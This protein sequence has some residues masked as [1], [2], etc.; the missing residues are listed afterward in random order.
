MPLPRFQ[1]IC[2]LRPGHLIFLLRWAA[3]LAGCAIAD[4]SAAEGAG[5]APASAL[6]NVRDQGAA[7][8]GRTLDSAALQRAIDLCAERGGGTVV[9]PA[10]TYLTG[11]LL[12]KNGVRLR[13][14]EGAT[15]LGSLSIADYRN[16][17]VFRDGTGAELGYALIAAVDAKDVALE[18]KGVIDGR[19]KQVLDGLAKAEHNKRPMLVRFVRCQRVSAHGVQLRNSA[20]WTANFFQ[21]TDVAIDGL[22]IASRGVGNNDGID[23]DSC[24]QVSITGCDIDS[25]DDA[26]CLKTT[27]ARPCRAISIADCRLK[28][29]HGAIKFGTESCANFE[30]ITVARCAIRETRN[31]GIKL[32]AVDGAHIRNVTISDLTMD[33]V[34][35]P[36]FVRLGAR[37]KTFRAGD[38]KRPV[39]GIENVVIRNVRARAAANAQLMPP[40]GIFITGIPGH[41]IENLRLENIA[42]ELAGGGQREHGRQVMEEAIDNYPEINRYGPRLPAFG[43]YAR[44]VKGLQAEGVTLTVA[45][46]DSRPALV[47]IDVDGAKFERWTFPSTAGAESLV[48]L[49]QAKTVSFE[50]FNVSGPTA[51]FLRVEGAGSS[52]IALTGFAPATAVEFAAGASPTSLSRR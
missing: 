30:D 5:P 17:D 47:A 35:T 20:A 40:S 39:G 34:A 6:L 51:P 12:I 43:L 19:G 21:C 8:D 10:G 22:T 26:I 45:S 36:I 13:L 11:T 1:V 7:G 15:L 29:N 50:H 4:A 25:G 49:E 44:H 32:L 27:S 33:D 28:S 46:A 2:R 9:V 3:L 18:G 38:E 23:L 48:R 31:G 14:D 37:L 41:S 52:G 16:V 24:D 42:I